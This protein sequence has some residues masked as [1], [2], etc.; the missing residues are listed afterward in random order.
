MDIPARWRSYPCADYLA[1]PWAESGFFCEESQTPVI[2][3]VAEV[4][5]LP[6]EPFLSVGWAGVD[7]IRFGYRATLPGLWAYYPI[8]REFEPVAASVGELVDR[9]TTNSI[10][11]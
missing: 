1:S 8:L 11:L 6:D 9:W 4:E 7:G 2:V 3:P 10:K 5:E